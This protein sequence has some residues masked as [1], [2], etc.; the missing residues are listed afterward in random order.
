MRKDND[1]YLDVLLAALLGATIAWAIYQ[2][3]GLAYADP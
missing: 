1:W 3:L 2:S